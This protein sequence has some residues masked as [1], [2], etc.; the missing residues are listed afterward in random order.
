M[1]L[2]GSLEVEVTLLDT[3]VPDRIDVHSNTYPAAVLLLPLL[4]VLTHL[5]ALGPL[6]KERADL[7]TME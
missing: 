1:S 7:A 5:D 4:L 3:A 6:V 2:V